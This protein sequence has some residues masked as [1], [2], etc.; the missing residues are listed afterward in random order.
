MGEAFQVFFLL[1][2]EYSCNYLLRTGSI[3]ARTCR[4]PE[5]CHEHWKSRKRL[6]CNVCGK[7]TTLNPAFV[8]SMLTVIM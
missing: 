5:G 8:E 2:G 1:P 3:C 6:P 7:P 4:Q